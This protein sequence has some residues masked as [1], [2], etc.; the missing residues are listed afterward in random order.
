MHMQKY[1]FAKKLK[2]LFEKVLAILHLGDPL[3]QIHLLL[4]SLPLRA[5]K[6]NLNT[7]P[8]NKQIFR[9]L[10]FSS[11]FQNQMKNL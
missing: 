5:A 10:L 9:I 3:V 4:P 6:H 2:L 8:T 11:Y 7:A 1:I